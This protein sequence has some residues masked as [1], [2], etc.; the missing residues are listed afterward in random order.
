MRRR[1]EG[2]AARRPPGRGRMP[3][4][5]G[6]ISGKR[7]VHGRPISLSGPDRTAV[8]PPARPARRSP[9]RRRR[10]SRWAPVQHQLGEDV[11]QAFGLL[12]VE[13]GHR[14]AVWPGSP[15]PAD[16]RSAPRAR[17]GEQVTWRPRQAPR[18]RTGT[19]EDVEPAGGVRPWHGLR[20]LAGG[21]VPGE[22]GADRR[23]HLRVYRS[24]GA[25]TDLQVGD[26]DPASVRVAAV[27]GGEGRPGVV[28]GDDHAGSGRAGP[29]RRWR[30][31]DHR[32]PGR[33]PP[34][35]AW[36]SVITNAPM[37]SP[38]TTSS[39]ACRTGTRQPSATPTVPPNPTP[40]NH[41]G[42]SQSGK[43]LRGTVQPGHRRPTVRGPI[44]SPCPR[45][46]SRPRP[47]HRSRRPPPADWVT[48]GTG[49]RRGRA[50]RGHGDPPVGAPGADRAAG[51]HRRRLPVGPE[52]LGL[53][54]LL[55]RR[56]GPGRHQELEGVLLRLARLL[57]LHHRRQA[58]RRRCG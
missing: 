32:G 8:R 28:D 53:R 10:G 37:R 42:P 49:R 38:G 34:V 15:G 56:R 47:R 7:C 52:R 16:G 23:G 9:G 6:S 44:M 1:Q 29:P 27:G 50:A 51:A 36:D 5:N 45:S 24:P 58:A 21:E 43:D 41:D 30:S 17:T 14:R 18:R 31:S 33:R 46:C 12:G 11:T 20:H 2:H 22:S 19:N 48:S 55:L 57:E 25:V 4:S 26:A 39:D 40:D 13:G 54:Q 35:S 3:W